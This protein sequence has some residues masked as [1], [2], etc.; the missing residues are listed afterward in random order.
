MI[1]YSEI[2]YMCMFEEIL[3]KSSVEMTAIHLIQLYTYISFI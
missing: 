1:V 3:A 2:M